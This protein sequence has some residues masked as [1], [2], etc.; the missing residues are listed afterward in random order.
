M[1]NSSDQ[2]RAFIQDE[3]GKIASDNGQTMT[4]ADD[5]L[6]LVHT[7]LLDSYGFIRL[8]MSLEQRF[9]FQLDFGEMD[10]EEFSTLGG[11]V[12]AAA[13]AAGCS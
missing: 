2:I 12:R 13:R 6:N 10:P 9:N 3:L 4:L 1:D 11:L 7:G 5:S 8:V